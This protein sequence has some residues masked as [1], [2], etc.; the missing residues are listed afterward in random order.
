MCLKDPKGERMRGCQ[1]IFTCEWRQMGISYQSKKTSPGRPGSC[2]ATNQ[3]SHRRPAPVRTPRIRPL[4]PRK[5]L[6]R[7]QHAHGSQARKLH[8]HVT[9]TRRASA[10]LAHG[11]LTPACDQQTAHGAHSGC[12]FYCYFCYCCYC[13]CLTLLSFSLL[14]LLSPTPH[15]PPSDSIPTRPSTSSTPSPTS[16][17]RADEL[18]IHPDVNLTV[19]AVTPCRPRS[20]CLTSDGSVALRYTSSPDLLTPSCPNTSPTS[21]PDSSF[22]FHRHILCRP[23][24]SSRSLSSLL[25]CPPSFGDPVLS[26]ASTLEHIPCGPTRPRTLLRQQSLQQPLMNPPGSG[27]GQP[28]TTSQSL[29]QL[30]TAP[31]HPGGGGAAG[32]GEAGGGGGE[33]GGAG[34]R[35]A[36]RAARGSPTGAGAA[37]YRGGGAGGRTRANPGSWDYMMDQIR[38]RGLDV[39][40]F[41]GNKPANS[42]KGQPP[43]ADGHSSVTDLANSL[44]GDMVMLSP[45]SEDDD[46]EG[47]ISEKLGRIQFSIGYSFQNTTLTVKL[48]RGQE[49]PAKDFSGTSDPF[50][51]IY[52]LPDKK[53]KLETKVKRKNLNPHWNETFLFE[54][55]P[56]EKVRERTLYLQVLDYDRF[57]RNDPIGEVSIPLNKVEL[58][59]IKT[60]WKELKP[61]S[62]G[63]GRRGD[64][65]L[66]LCYNPTAN[67]ITVNIIKA[68]NLKAMDIGGTSDPYV[69]VWLMHKDR[70]VEKKKTVT[71]KRCL[72]PVFNESF[73]FD[74]PAHVLRE[75]TII[76]TVMDKDR[77]SRNDVIGKIY[78]SWKSGPAEVKHWKD[79]LARPRTNVAQ[80][81]ALK[82]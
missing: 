21:S 35:A 1:I 26:Y 6:L 63:S 79:M 56:Y 59:Q 54:G 55:F 50:V 60:F 42:P 67:T 40:S 43:D 52:L 15:D 9:Q 69:K 82:A 29:G 17:S 64:L 45:G 70:R 71:M 31:G 11:W 66:S 39:K 14:L 38:N 51:K 49:L 8:S 19:S 27:F 81:H 28:P 16:T 48:L 80:W 7:K 20:P 62:D 34:K 37:R 24:P 2:K 25:L 3:T 53:H 76:I 65:L 57:S 61:C 58:G 36:P 73:P 12:T 46:G 41:L 74:V 4:P 10:Q 32:R 75:T 68:R 47:P 72:N 78:L 23:W 18:S 77:L 22:S 30:H 13:C 44:T 5:T 33:G